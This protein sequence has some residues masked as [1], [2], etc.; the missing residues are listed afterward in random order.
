MDR[1]SKERIPTIEIYTDGSCK[2]TG[3]YSTFGG[4][5]FVV[6]VAD[7]KE[8]YNASGSV[9]GTTNQRMELQAVIEA[10]NYAQSIRRGSERVIV[11]SDSAYII[12]CYRKEWYIR[13]EKNGWIN[14][15]GE[16]VINRDLWQQITPFFDNY[17]YSFQHVPGHSEIY[18]NEY[19][20][21]LAQTQ[22]ETLKHKWRGLQN[23]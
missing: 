2:R 13:W 16:G 17:W 20:D 8:I 9:Y 5:A 4:W 19:C 3:R 14:A 23:E 6:V 18:W 21:K 10:L 1:R 11:Y 22:A 15:R 12:N 7:G